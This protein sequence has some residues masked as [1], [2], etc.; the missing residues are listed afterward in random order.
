MNNRIRRRCETESEHKL[1]K[2]WTEDHFLDI[3]DEIYYILQSYSLIFIIKNL[4]YTRLNIIY[5]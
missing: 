3:L 1:I 5:K 4:S 2:S